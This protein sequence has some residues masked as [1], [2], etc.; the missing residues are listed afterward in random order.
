MKKHLLI[1]VLLCLA[2]AFESNAQYGYYYY[3]RPRMRVRVVPRVKRPAPQRQTPH[4]SVPFEP[5]VNISI[6]YGFPNLDK[7]HLAEF[8]NFYKGNFSQTGPVTGSIDYQFSPN[9][10]IGVMGTYG[11]VS[12][13]YYSYSSQTNLPDFTGKLEN[14]S[15]MLNMMTYFPTYTRKVEPYLKTA[16]GVNNWKQD[17]VDEA[18]NKVYDTDDPSQLA[19]QVS[20]GARFNLSKNAGL[21]VEG[22]YGKYILNG[23]LTFKF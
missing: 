19:Y 6:G 15:V 9:I 12:A 2:F 14:W 10:S 5:S 21:Y 23:G 8:Y 3:G 1:I 20:L 16:I 11:K 7:D 22:G 17:Y 13:P 18:G 4:K